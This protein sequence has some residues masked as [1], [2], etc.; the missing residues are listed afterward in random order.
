MANMTLN[1]YAPAL[2]TRDPRDVVESTALEL[3]R[4]VGRIGRA[5]LTEPRAPG[6]WSARD[7]LCHL[8]DCEIVFAYRLRQTLA[9]DHHRIQPF[10][11]DKWAAGYGDRDAN[12]ALAT[13]EAVRNWNVAL[14]KRV[15]PVQLSRPVTHPERGS[16][17]FQTV[18][19]TMGGHDLHHLKQLDEIA[20][21][22]A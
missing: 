11:Q 10:D 18:V 3:H 4:L 6:K 1:P 7:I 21:R 13:F 12:L 20:E 2:G 8:A 9:E 14:L 19:D 22:S 17:T 5:R 15:T 16:M